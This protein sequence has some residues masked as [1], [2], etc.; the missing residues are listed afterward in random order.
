MA[1]RKIEGRKPAEKTARQLRIEELRSVPRPE[2]TSEQSAELLK[3]NSEE[4]RSRF[5]RL[6]PA[7]AGKLKRAVRGLVNLGNVQGYEYTPD[8]AQAVVNAFNVYMAE[9]RRAFTGAPKE[10]GMWDL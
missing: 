9:V 4:K 6:L 10:K 2:R 3:L 5:L 8:E 7:R 1:K